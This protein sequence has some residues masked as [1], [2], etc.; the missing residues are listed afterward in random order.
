MVKIQFEQIPSDIWNTD[1]WL[2]SETRDGP[3]SRDLV[4]LMN[5]SLTNESRKYNLTIKKEILRN[6]LCV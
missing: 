3:L 4:S 2:F 1:M 5:D 6:N